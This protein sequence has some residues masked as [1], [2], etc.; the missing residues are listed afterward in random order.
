MAEREDRELQRYFDGELS[1][2]QARQVRERLIESADDQRRLEALGEMRGLLREAAEAEADDADFSRLWDGVRTGIATE[3]G[4]A[5]RRVGSWVLRWGMVTA[6][7]V[8]V[9][10]LVLV[11]WSPLSSPPPRND[12]TIEDLEVGQGAISTIFTIADPELADA[13][14]VIW[15]DDSQDSQESQR[16]RESQGEL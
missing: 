10:V 16:I 8:A 4:R 15:V 5:P 9:A 6:S 13:T 2:R 1:L 12:C 14:T 7:A 11:L 3:K